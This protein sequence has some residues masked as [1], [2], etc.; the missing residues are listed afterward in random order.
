MEISTTTVAAVR[1]GKSAQSVGHLAK[2]AVAEARAAGADLPRNAQGMAASA[3][4]RGADPASVFAAMIVV[5]EPV[6]DD[7]GGV[8][9]DATPP[10]VEDSPATV[11]DAGYGAAADVLSPGPETGAETALTLLR[12]V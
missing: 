4:A 11:A 6:V 5:P 3:I 10:A 12:D 8:V 2:A 9:D 7:G 1:P